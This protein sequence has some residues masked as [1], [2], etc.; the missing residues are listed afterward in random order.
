MQQFVVVKVDG[1]RN[2]H[3][4]VVVDDKG[5]PRLK[6][7]V[8]VFLFPGAE[9]AQS[10]RRGIIGSRFSHQE[11]CL[12]LPI[13]A[14]VFQAEFVKM[15]VQESKESAVGNQP[16]QGGNTFQKL[17]IGQDY[18]FVRRTKM[19]HSPIGQNKILEEIDKYSKHN[20]NYIV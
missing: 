9:L 12:F 10:R 4:V 14:R 13:L 1:N 3:R 8:P 18:Y 7:L 15:F 19:E 16:F 11:R 2:G 5:I 17:D 6:V 20:D